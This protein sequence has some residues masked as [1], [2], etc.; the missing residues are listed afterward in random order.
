MGDF[1]GT[2]DNEENISRKYGK[3]DGAMVPAFWNRRERFRGYGGNVPA[4][5]YLLFG[6]G[7]EHFVGTG[8]N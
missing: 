8:H 2:G 1:P 6:C 7:W 4:S 3:F 5:W